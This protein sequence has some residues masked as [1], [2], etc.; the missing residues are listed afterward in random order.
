MESKSWEVEDLRDQPT[1]SSR[2]GWWDRCCT[3]N[4]GVATQDEA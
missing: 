3:R 2:Y 4:E 1:S